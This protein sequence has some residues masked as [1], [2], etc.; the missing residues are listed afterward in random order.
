MHRRKIGRRTRSIIRR[1]SRRQQQTDTQISL[2]SSPALKF[3]S[4]QNSHY[5]EEEHFSDTQRRI[6]RQN[7]KNHSMMF[8]DASRCF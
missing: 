7:V 3:S 4:L 5:L 1:R 6:E 2:L 8:H